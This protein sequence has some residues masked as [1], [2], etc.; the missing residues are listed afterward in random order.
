MT[1]FWMI[2]DRIINFI[3]VTQYRYSVYKVKQV[4]KKKTEFT[5]AKK[6]DDW[7]Y[8]TDNLY[9]NNR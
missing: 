2:R 6:M 4:F 1:P 5:S 3:L 7:D 8:A 9:L